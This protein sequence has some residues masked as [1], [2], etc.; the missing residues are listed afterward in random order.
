[1]EIQRAFTVDLTPISEFPGEEEELIIPGV[2]FNVRQMD[3]DKDK[4]KHLFY[5]KLKQRF[6]R[7]YDQF[8]HNSCDMIRIFL[9]IWVQFIY[10][11]VQVDWENFSA[12]LNTRIS[13]P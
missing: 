5:L 6:N 2:C 11:Y 12:P 4:N 1:M 3:F 9:R 10:E 7:K 13:F 8:F